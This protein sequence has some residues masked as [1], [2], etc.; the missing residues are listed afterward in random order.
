MFDIASP[1]SDCDELYSAPAGAPDRDRDRARQG[2]DRRDLSHDKVMAAPRSHDS[3]HD[4]SSSLDQ[5][6]DR[7]E[8]I[9]REIASIAPIVHERAR[10]LRA[11]ALLRGDPE[12]SSG[13]RPILRPRITRE[14]VF[15]YLARKPG[16]RAG[17]IAAGLGVDQG[18][19]SAHLYRGKGRL[20]VSRGGRWYPVP[21][22]DEVARSV[23]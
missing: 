19:V 16:S 8:E 3:H 12:P 13:H 10:L 23:R 1:L 2:R 18:A 7:I 6:E 15:E 5:I 9:E 21:A 22:A 11:R 4:M 20:F 14:A 17:E